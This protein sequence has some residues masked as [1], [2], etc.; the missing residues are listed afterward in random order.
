MENFIND[1]KDNDIILNQ[2][3]EIKLNLQYN[4]IEEE[5]EKDKNYYRYQKKKSKIQKY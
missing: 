5:E 1:I 3:N 2:I 4:N